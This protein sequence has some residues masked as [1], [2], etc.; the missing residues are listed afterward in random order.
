MDPCLVIGDFNA[1]PPPPP[2][3]HMVVPQATRKGTGLLNAIHHY[4]FTLQDDLTQPTRIG[5]RVTR[6]AIPDL[7]FT[8]NVKTPTWITQLDTLGSDRLVGR[9][10]IPPHHH[11]H[12]TGV[13]KLTD[14]EAFLMDPLPHTT[15]EED[16]DRWAQSS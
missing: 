6:F 1:P 4:Y 11:K 14:W 15:L 8:R 9:I 13:A 2:P 3:H 16:P 10:T 12:R 7:T 5:I